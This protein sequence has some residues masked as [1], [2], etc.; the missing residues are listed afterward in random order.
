MGVFHFLKH[1]MVVG[2]EQRTECCCLSSSLPPLRWKTHLTWAVVL[3]FESLPRVTRLCLRP[4]HPAVAPQSPYWPCLP[5]GCGW[6]DG[7]QECASAGRSSLC[8]SDKKFYSESLNKIIPKDVQESSDRNDNSVSP[9]FPCLK[10]MRLN[11]NDLLSVLEVHLRQEPDLGSW[12]MRAVPPVP[13]LRFRV[14]LL[15]PTRLPL[16][17]SSTAALPWNA[18]TAV[19][20]SLRSPTPVPAPPEVSSDWASPHLPRPHLSSY[21]PTCSTEAL[22]VSSVLFIN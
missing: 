16:F 8:Q 6:S 14:V 5:C 21:K 18:C 9:I 17:L 11:D 15:L 10:L 13:T 20:P 7:L 3:I 12:L 1:I 2:L 19:L 4:P 22:R